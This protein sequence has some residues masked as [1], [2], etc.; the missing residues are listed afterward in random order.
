MQVAPTLEQL[1]D[2]TKLTALPPMNDDAAEGEEEREGVAKRAADMARRVAHTQHKDAGVEEWAEVRNRDPGPGSGDP[3]GS[4]GCCSSFHRQLSKCARRCR[5]ASC[6][7]AKRR[8]RRSSR[9]ASATADSAPLHLSSSRHRYGWT[10]A[11][12]NV[13]T[14]G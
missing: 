8:S 6:T 11:V 3:V 12:S 5:S 14:I 9:D 13:S 1:I 4:N 7:R 10:D 2:V